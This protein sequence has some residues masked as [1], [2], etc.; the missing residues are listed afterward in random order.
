MG[1]NQFVEIG[2]IQRTHGVSGEFQ[3]VWNDDFYLEEQNLESVFIEFD[4]IPVPFFIVSIRSKGDDKAL[5][6]LDD[7]EDVNIADELV[8]RKLLLPADEIVEK[9]DLLLNDLIGYTM[10]SDQK[11]LIGSIVDFQQYQS[12]SVFT[13]EHQTGK[14]VMIPVA[15]ELIVEVDT[16]QK[17]ITLV[18]P[19]GLIDLYLE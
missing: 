19:N 13:V 18:I 16:D 1:S 15:D 11:L 17:T 10:F 14:E 6:K 4:G 12:N 8:G 3:V 9:D 7:V 5:V 2:A